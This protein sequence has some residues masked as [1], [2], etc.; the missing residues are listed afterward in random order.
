MLFVSRLSVLV[1]AVGAEIGCRAEGSTVPACEARTFNSAGWY[2]ANARWRTSMR[3]RRLPVR[4]GSYRAADRKLPAE[5]GNRTLGRIPFPMRP[6]TPRQPQDYWR[7][8][9]QLATS[10]LP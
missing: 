7:V 8:S 5:A 9:V 2:P 3:V 6:Y 1:R 4:E 10:A